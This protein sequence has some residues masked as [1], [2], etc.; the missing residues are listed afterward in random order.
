MFIGFNINIARHGPSLL[1]DFVRP[2]PCI[3][4]DVVRPCPCAST[5]IDPA[6][7]DA[8]T[9][10]H[11]ARLC[12][13][14]PPVAAR[15]CAL[16]STRPGVSPTKITSVPQRKRRKSDYEAIARNQRLLTSWTEKFPWLY[17]DERVDKLFCS[18]CLCHGTPHT[19]ADE[20]SPLVLGSDS[21]WKNR[22]DGLITHDGSQDQRRDEAAHKT[23][24]GPMG[25]VIEKMTNEKTAVI[26]NLLHTA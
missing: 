19:F 23:Q 10:S 16:P 9:S 26:K 14:T 22:K 25:T 2:C 24:R 18:W 15:P 20:K 6:Y 4:L 8:S 11:A 3:C 5:S 17:K 7:A 1:A 12:A 13:S 21:E